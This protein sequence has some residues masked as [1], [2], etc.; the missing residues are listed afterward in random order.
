MGICDWSSSGCQS[1]HFPAC[2]SQQKLW[3]KGQ[4]KNALSTT[5]YYGWPK[6]LQTS[7][8]EL[9]VMN[10]FEK[11][12]IL[13]KEKTGKKDFAESRDLKYKKWYK[14]L[15]WTSGH[16]KKN[17]PPIPN[18]NFKPG[19]FQIPSDL[20][21]KKYE[22]TQISK[23]KYNNLEKRFDLLKSKYEQSQKLKRKYNRLLERFN[24]LKKKYNAE[25]IYF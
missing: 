15:L 16:L 12:K 25:W 13:I 7:V 11:L 20:L 5:K 4:E 2:F 6:K 24:N 8:N 19:I 22:R 9:Y 14:I 18:N 3:G 1:F 23:K 10:N 21:K 17:P